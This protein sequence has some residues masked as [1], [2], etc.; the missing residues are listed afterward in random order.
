MPAASPRA[1]A[2]P[3]WR[4]CWE[5]G[6]VF[7]SAYWAELGRVAVTTAAAAPLRPAT[8]LR[9]AAKWPLRTAGTEF[10]NIGFGGERRR[11]EG[12][13]RGWR[14]HFR[15][16]FFSNVDKEVTEKRGT[17]ALHLKKPTGES[18]GGAGL[19]FVLHYQ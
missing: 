19:G 13:S 10:G 9:A 5:L 6:E 2:G 15:F 12:L 7:L 8:S 18:C 1:P 17:P 4:G 3:R 16:R 11:R 14:G